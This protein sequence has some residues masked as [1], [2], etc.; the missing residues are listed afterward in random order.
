MGV[1][2]EQMSL[3]KRNRDLLRQ[4]A[5]AYGPDKTVHIKCLT[6]GEA[7]M[8]RDWVKK[9]YPDV[10]IYFTWGAF[11]PDVPGM[12][13]ELAEVF[14]AARLEHGTSGTKGEE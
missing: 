9:A 13:P 2:H 5:R 4:A 14:A 12:D 3:D 8:L 10:T 6:E 11:P 7:N 1:L